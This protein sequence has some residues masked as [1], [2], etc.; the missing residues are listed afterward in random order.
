MDSFWSQW[1]LILLTALMIGRVIRALSPEQMI[2]QITLLT[3][4]IFLVTLLLPLPRLVK[5]LQNVMEETEEEAVSSALLDTRQE[6]LTSVRQ[7]LKEICD[8]NLERKLELAGFEGCLVSVS[9]EENDDGQWQISR[10]LFSVPKEMSSHREEI[11]ILLQEE[12]GV[13]P[14]EVEQL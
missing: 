8:E 7:H 3:G 6:T 2:R 13:F 9:L 14:Q 4:G 5:D 12:T 11:C 10:L 1:A